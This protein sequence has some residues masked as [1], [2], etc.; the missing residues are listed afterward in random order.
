M[1]GTPRVVFFAVV[2]FVYFRVECFTFPTIGSEGHV[3]AEQDDNF[4]FYKTDV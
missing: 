2:I 4:C 3:K 1:L